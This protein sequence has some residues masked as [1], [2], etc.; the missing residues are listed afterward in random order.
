MEDIVRA[1]SCSAHPSSFSQFSQ[2]LPTAPTVPLHSKG[3]HNDINDME[4]F[5]VTTNN[6]LL[7]IALVYE[8]WEDTN[9]TRVRW[10]VASVFNRLRPSLLR[11]R[12]KSATGSA[13]VLFSDE[14]II[15]RVSRAL[16]S[17][18]S[19]T[20]AITCIALSALSVFWS[21]RFDMFG[22]ICKLT[23][24]KLF[25]EHECALLCIRRVCKETPSFAVG[26]TRKLLKQVGIS[27]LVGLY[28]IF[29]FVAFLQ[30]SLITLP[31][32][33]KLALLRVLVAIGHDASSIAS[34]RRF[35]LLFLRQ[36]PTCE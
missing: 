20:R 9:S 28:N 18:D 30:V 35:C 31:H 22:K 25:Y 19:V 23:R 10:F 8:Q 2:L 13:S 32:S 12:D 4:Q 33:R 5:G 17:N 21:S 15:T 24:S 1:I 11:A 16:D 27:F 34:A 36:F 7:T 14:L 6:A 26:L 29:D 3:T